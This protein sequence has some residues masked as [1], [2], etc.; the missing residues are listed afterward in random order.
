M[1]RGSPRDHR[2]RWALF[3]G[4]T[5]C[6]IVVFFLCAIPV[7]VWVGGGAIVDAVIVGNT[8]PVANPSDWP[9]PLQKLRKDFGATSLP[10]S[11]IQV[12][13]LCHGM[14]HEY[15]WRMDAI[16]GLF[17]HIQKRWQLSPVS[18]PNSVV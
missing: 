7:V 16:P 8:G 14:D 3:I 10:T 11:K 17:K 4:V 5:L 6:G 15:V 1:E 12:H 13:C 18:N 9:E 2:G